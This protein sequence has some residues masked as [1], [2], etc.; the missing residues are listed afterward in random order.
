MNK[1]KRVFLTAVFL[2][3]F[4]S[5][6]FAG[7][8]IDLQRIISIESSGNAKAY[9]AFSKARGLCQITPICLQE[10]NNFHN[11]KYNLADLFNPEINKLI[12]SW[13]LEIRIPQLLQH[14]KIEATQRNIIICYNAGIGTLTKNK[15]LKEETRNYII[16][17]EKL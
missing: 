13:Y 7:N 14:F 16:K 3:I 1:S 5:S 12:A 17:Y 8:R 6:A 11:I 9:N 2:L 10:Y 4:H 15:T